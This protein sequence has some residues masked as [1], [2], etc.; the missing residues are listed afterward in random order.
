MWRYEEYVKQMMR[1]AEE[2]ARL[3]RMIA[4]ARQ[5]ATLGDPEHRPEYHPVTLAATDSTSTLVANAKGTVI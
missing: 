4:N 3:S 1:E 2:R 5:L